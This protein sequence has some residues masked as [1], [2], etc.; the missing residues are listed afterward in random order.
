MKETAAG[1]PCRQSPCAMSRF[2]HLWTTE[3]AGGNDPVTTQ[4]SEIKVEVGQCP[5][6]ALLGGLPPLGVHPRIN[7]MSVLIRG[8]S[9]KTG[10]LLSIRLRSRCPAALCVLSILL[11]GDRHF[12]ESEVSLSAACEFKSSFALKHW[13]WGGKTAECGGAYAA[14]SMPSST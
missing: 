1:S 4:S 10:L 11:R 7:A 9:R 14:L 6:G 8:S 5:N 12:F 3:R 2:C 13:T